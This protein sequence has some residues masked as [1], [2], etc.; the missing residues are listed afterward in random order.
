MVGERIADMKLPKGCPLCGGDVH[1]RLS[2]EGARTYCPA[3]HLITKPQLTMSAEG[4]TF[5]LPNVPQA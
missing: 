3:C 5:E 4:V 2:P 1:V